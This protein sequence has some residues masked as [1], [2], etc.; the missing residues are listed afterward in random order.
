MRRIY[1]LLYL[2]FAAF[3]TNGQTLV[4][5]CSGT[6]I[7][8]S[9]TVAYPGAT[10]TWSAPVPISGTI[11]GGTFTS[12]GN[13]SVNETLVNSSATSATVAYSVTESFGSTTF[14]LIVT[15]NP[16]PTVNSIADQLL[17]KG[18][19]TNLVNFT[20]RLQQRN[21]IG[22]ITMLLLAL[23][24]QG[25]VISMHLQPPMELMHSYPDL[26]Q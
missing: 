26:L 10:Y 20:G 22:S 5:S 4:T 23:L 25:P 14:T 8:Y 24:F 1:L 18:T 21:I 6:N 11:T 2:L 16:I 19:L 15:V 7:N 12:V 3:V 17:C 9:N 13:A